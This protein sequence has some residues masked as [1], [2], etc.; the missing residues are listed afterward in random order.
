MIP[1]IMSALILGVAGFGKTNKL[2]RTGWRMFKFTV[3]T[4]VIAVFIGYVLVKIIRPGAGFSQE[5][6]S[7]L[8]SKYSETTSTIKN[9]I[10]TNTDHG[11]GHTITNLFPKNPFEDMVHAFD[12]N[13][14][15][16]GMIAV[17]V[18]SLIIG[19]ALL[20]SPAEK[21][22]V[23][24]SFL[25]GLY[26]VVMKVVH[27]GMLLAPFGVASLLF[28]LT[29]SIGISFITILIKYMLVVLLAL[30]IQQFMVFSLILK[31]LSNTN[32]VSFF[33][34]IREVMITAFSTSSGS[35][36]LPIAIE[37]ST[38]K[39]KMPRDI[40]NFILTI[41][42]T[43]NQNGTAIYQGISIIFLAQC[44]GIDLNFSQDCI[45]MACAIF[46]GIGTVGVPGGSMPILMLILIFLGIPAESIAIIYG[47]DRIMDMCRTVVNVTGDLVAVTYINTL[48]QNENAIVE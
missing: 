23:F 34:N 35:A 24:K 29:L 19:I 41:G 20:K 33:K 28:V 46:A 44:F 43:T 12:P 45:V 18:F 16:G 22:V 15:G 8:M 27:F 7:Q 32:P 31:Y 26:T 10:A 38:E 2:G 48:E 6:L 21:T 42:S 14:T 13:Y 9:S 30:A 39:L 4:T 3:V 40:S 1:L 5:T 36:S 25:E 17:M 37:T 47:L 11:L